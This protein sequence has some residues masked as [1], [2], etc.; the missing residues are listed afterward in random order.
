MELFKKAMKTPGNINRP[1]YWGDYANGLE[2][3]KRKGQMQQG[4]FKKG[5]PEAKGERTTRPYTD[6]HEG[7]LSEQTTQKRGGKRGG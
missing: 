1:S 5:D 4:G 2:S 3:T 6:V 7:A